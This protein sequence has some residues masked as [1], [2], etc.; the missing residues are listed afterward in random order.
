[1]AQAQKGDKVKI[2]YTGTLEDGTI[3]DST[4]EM[5]ECCDDSCDDDCTDE[6]CGCG[7]H[8]PGPMEMTI[9]DVP[10]FP[11]IDE[12]LEG[13]APGEKKIVVITAADAFGDYDEERVFSVPRSDLPE[14]MEV[15][16]V[17]DEMVLVNDDEEEMGVAV[18]EVTDTEVTFDA[19]HPLAGHDLSFELELVEI[20]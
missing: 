18:I 20:L 3:F 8:E 15:P 19:N 1:M 16:E 12:A 10:M 2:N 7:D 13:M 4:L 9:G 5:E 17:G 14:D 6:G 11:Q